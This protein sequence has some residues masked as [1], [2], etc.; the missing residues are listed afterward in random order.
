M[1]VDQDRS[2]ASRA[3]V[4]AVGS[5]DALSVIDSVSTLSEAFAAIRRE[6]AV[7]VVV[8]PRGLGSARRAATPPTVEIFYQTAFLSTGA[9]TSALLQATITAELARQA[10]SQSGLAGVALLRVPLPG[11]R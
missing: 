11:W 10:P 6:R 7:A 9:L 5:V 4:R 8:L 3:I 1:I 2:T